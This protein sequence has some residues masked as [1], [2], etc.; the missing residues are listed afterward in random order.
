MNPFNNHLETLLDRSRICNLIQ[1]SDKCKNVPGLMVEVGLFRGGSLD[2]LSFF[3]PQREFYGFD[4]FEGLPEPSEH[5]LH[6]QGEF[7]GVDAGAMSAYFRFIRHNVRIVKGFVPD[8][9][10]IFA[11]H[12]TFSF[13]HIDVDL[14]KSILDSLDYFVPRMNVGGIII[15]DDYKFK[16]TPGCKIAIEEFFSNKKNKVSHRSELTFADG[17]FIGQYIIIK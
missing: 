10:K 17:S 15:L 11:D 12:E 8:T 14:Y 2:I 5:D 13:V 1:Y 4:S 9:F 6:N 7:G 3:N 16:S